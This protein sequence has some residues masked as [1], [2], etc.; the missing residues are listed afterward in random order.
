MNDVGGYFEIE[1][2]N[3]ELGALHNNAIKLNAAR[4]ALEYIVKARKYSKVY[5]PYFI[6][7]V[8][9]E[10][11]RRI[12]VSIEFYHIDTNMQLVTLPALKGDEA[13]LY[14][15]YF[16]FM[17]E[18]AKELARKIKNLIVDNCQSLFTAPL[19][20]I[21]TFYSLR[22]FVGVPDGAFL[23][24]GAGINEDIPDSG[25]A[26]SVA[27][28]YL[29]KN[30]NA[31]AGFEAFRESEVAFDHFPM[32]RMSTSTEKFLLTYD[33]A[34]NKLTRERNFLV[35]HNSLASINE[36]KVI[37]IRNICG[38]L[39]YPF[40]IKNE[41]LRMNLISNNFFISMLWPNLDASLSPE[42]YELYLTRNLLPLPVDQRYGVDEMHRM[43]TTIFTLLK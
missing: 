15:N 2:S 16:G 5:I 23:Y 22:K 27:H 32:S 33:F 42:S 20:G 1:Y 39:Y 17:N 38:P 35:L 4:Y 40:L 34:K 7:D 10:K 31:Q 11:L 30:V 28:L 24:C 19:P 26:A 9:C 43:L 25:N 14:V 12:G 3:I 36:Y 13:L 41:G 6:C 21:D 18:Y 29:R 8:V 37:D